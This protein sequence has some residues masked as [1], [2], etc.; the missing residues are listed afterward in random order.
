[1]L[2]AYI[3]YLLGPGQQI[4]TSLGYAPLPAGLDAQAKAQLDKIGT[5]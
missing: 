4:L 2:Q 3:G 1:M 5:P